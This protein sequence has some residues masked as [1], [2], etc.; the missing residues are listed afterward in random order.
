MRISYYDDGQGGFVAVTSHCP[1]GFKD[2]LFIGKGPIPGGGIETVRETAYE[3]T[4]LSKLR[5]IQTVPDDWMRAFG[6]EQPAEPVEVFA[7]SPRPV[8]IPEQ[9]RSDVVEIVWKRAERHYELDA[10]PTQV[11]LL[12]LAA[13]GLLFVLALVL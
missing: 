4:W 2:V 11:L 8:V 5:Q 1:K 13:A 3:K 6:Y 10:N 9:T 12:V 7:P